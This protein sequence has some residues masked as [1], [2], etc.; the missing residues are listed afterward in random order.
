[1]IRNAPFLSFGTTDFFLY[2][3]AASFG[4]VVRFPGMRRRGAALRGFLLA[5]FFFADGRAGFVAAAFCGFGLAVRDGAAA[6]A[7]RRFLA[8][9]LR[10]TPPRR[11]GL[12]VRFTGVIGIKITK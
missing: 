11:V 3:L 10:E 7:A 4:G 5:G 1:M 2:K 12:P 6:E 8:P 9:L